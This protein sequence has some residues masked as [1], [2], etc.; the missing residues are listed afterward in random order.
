MFL[1]EFLAGIILE[2]YYSLLLLLENWDI[3]HVSH[4]GLTCISVPGTEDLSCHSE[5]ECRLYFGYSRTA[6]WIGGHLIF[7][8][9]LSF[10]FFTRPT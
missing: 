3:P 2:K 4:K 6:D 8:T 9:Y 5:G 7:L 10:E 1:V